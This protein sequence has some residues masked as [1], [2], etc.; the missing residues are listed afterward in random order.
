MTG[1]NNGREIFLNLERPLT[2]DSLYGGDLICRQYR[3]GYRFSVD[4]I[5]AAHFCRIS[6]SGRVLDLGCG[7]GIIALILTRLHQK[8]EVVGLEMQHDLA[9]L[10]ELNVRENGLTSRIRIIEGDARRVDD[11][12]RAESFDLVVCNPPYRK[13]GSG[14]VNRA[15]EAAIARHEIKGNLEDMLGAASYAVKNRCPVVFIYPAVRFA[16]LA[17]RLARKRLALKRVRPVYSYPECNRATLVM[18]EAVKNG[19]EECLFLPPFYIYRGK[20]KGYSPEMEKLY[21]MR[22]AAENNTHKRSA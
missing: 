3:D 22:F 13:C 2:D 10:A 18:V 20:N 8:L 21:S 5:L 17:T 15:D 4:S 12:F 16:H 9:A 19:G 14:R 6:V 7:S 1:K 11:L